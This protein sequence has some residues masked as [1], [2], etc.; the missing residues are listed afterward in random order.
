MVLDG[1][2]TAFRASSPEDAI[3]KYELALKALQAGKFNER[4]EKHLES[5][6]DRKPRRKR[7]DYSDN[8]T[9]RY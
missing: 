6:P 5:L 3:E 4:I 7:K 2:S 1:T 8:T 9:S